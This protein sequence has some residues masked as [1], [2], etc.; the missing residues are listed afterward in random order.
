[1]VAQLAWPACSLLLA[2]AVAVLLLSQST[3][4]VRAQAAPAPL[5][6]VAI[7]ASDSVGIGATDPLTQGWVPLFA[8]SL[9]SN[10]RL[11]NL[12]V[13]GSTAAQAVQEQLGPAMD[14]H[15]NVVTVWLAVNDLDDQVPLGTYAQSMNTLL[16][17]LHSTGARVLVGNVPDLAP[18]AAFHGVDPNAL[19][20]GIAAW[21][22]VIS[23]AVQRNGAQLVDLYGH[24]QELGQHPE[25]I[26]ADG[27]HPS[28]QGYQRIAQLFAQAYAQPD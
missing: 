21:N 20:F 11:V 22:M 5:T 28:A 24:W 15:P 27:F 17:G 12:G 8:Q 13:N 6:Y 19:S 3:A 23:D 10:T 9:G 25:Y 4:P 18:L 7:G 2:S 26:S 1:M 14:A 16:A